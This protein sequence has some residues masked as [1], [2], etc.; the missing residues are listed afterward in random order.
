[1]LVTREPHGGSAQPT[2]PAVL[3]ASLE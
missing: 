3:Q 1:V 2:T